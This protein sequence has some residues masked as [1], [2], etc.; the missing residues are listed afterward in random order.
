MEEI[1]NF[2]TNETNS[3]TR[4]I[5]EVN[6]SE[7]SSNREG[8]TEVIDLAKVFIDFSKPT[9]LKLTNQAEY[10]EEKYG[11]S[12]KKIL[13]I[14]NQIDNLNRKYFEEKERKT[15]LLIKLNDQQN[16]MSQ[17]YSKLINIFGLSEEEY[18]GVR[19]DFVHDAKEYYRLETIQ[20]EGTDPADPNAETD[21]DETDMWGF[22]E[23]DD[24]MS[25]EEREELIKKRKK[26]EEKQHL[27]RISRMRGH[28]SKEDDALS[29]S[30]RK[31]KAL[32]DQIHESKT[33][34]EKLLEEKK[35]LVIMRLPYMKE[36]LKNANTLEE[37]TIMVQGEIISKIFDP[38]P[39]P[40]HCPGKIHLDGRCY[41]TGKWDQKTWDLYRRL[42]R[43]PD[44]A[45]NFYYNL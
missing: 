13:N 26:E 16:S 2:L 30:N 9:Y 45:G 24:N 14:D 29:K 1:N 5:N 33:E 27:M 18:K 21:N 39:T 6:S 8:L 36:R 42:Y 38:H 17:Y 40:E 11:N 15:D 37:V 25:D 20:N 35:E 12:N 43:V 32:L 28:L 41:P 22:G 7:L 23:F 44:I 10:F 3:L 34:E 31:I 19:E 4:Q